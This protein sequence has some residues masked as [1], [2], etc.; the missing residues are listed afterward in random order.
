M[1][2][3]SNTTAIVSKSLVIRTVIIA[4]L[5]STRPGHF[6]KSWQ[7]TIRWRVVH[8]SRADLLCANNISLTT[9]GERERE[10]E[11]E[12][13]SLL[14]Q[15]NITHWICVVVACRCQKQHDFDHPELPVWERNEVWKHGKSI[16]SLLMEEHT[17]KHVLIS[18]CTKYSQNHHF[19]N[20]AQHTL[21]RRNKGTFDE[22]FHVQDLCEDWWAGNSWSSEDGAT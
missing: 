5:T 12:R 18:H 17:Q 14:L 6:V 8:H 2:P 9:S 19:K 20:F 13:E 7:L 3:I 1:C 10:R 15:R 22:T 11:R 21:N 16:E 4:Q